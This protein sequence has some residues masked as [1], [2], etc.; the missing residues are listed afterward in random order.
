MSVMGFAGLDYQHGRTADLPWPVTVPKDFLGGEGMADWAMRELARI[1]V[2]VPPH[3]RG[4]AA[5]VI[6]YV[7]EAGY[8]DG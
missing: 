2:E 3:L 1:G 4:P 6:A 7:Y 8:G 5:Q